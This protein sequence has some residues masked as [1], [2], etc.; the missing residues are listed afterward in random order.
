MMVNNCGYG[1]SNS[2]LSFRYVNSTLELC[3]QVGKLK[4][5]MSGLGQ[6]VVL[7]SMLLDISVVTKSSVNNSCVGLLDEVVWWL[8]G[9]SNFNVLLDSYSVSVCSEFSGSVMFRSEFNYMLSCFMLFYKV[10]FISKCFY[11]SL[12]TNEIGCLVDMIGRILSNVQ[13]YWFMKYLNNVYNVVNNGFA[14]DSCSLCVL[15]RVNIIGDYVNKYLFDVASVFRLSD[16]YYVL[17]FYL[18]GWLNWSEFSCWVSGDI[19]YFYLSTLFSYGYSNVMSL[20]FVVLHYLVD[21]LK[22]VMVNVFNLGLGAVCNIWVSSFIF[23]GFAYELS[24]LDLWVLVFL[25]I[26]V[27]SI[28]SFNYFWS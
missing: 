11:E 23:K 14:L 27:K 15:G 18:K 17:R 16:E 2:F 1:L 19:N 22:K 26:A 3:D 13:V 10:S 8:W 21:Y 7:V 5:L 25:I 20:V 9:S 6:M 12:I 4:E 24:T 28:R